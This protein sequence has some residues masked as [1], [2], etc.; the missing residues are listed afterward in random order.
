[1]HAFYVMHL[2]PVTVAFVKYIIVE[3]CQHMFSFSADFYSFFND[4]FFVTA[5]SVSYI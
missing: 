5:Y 4:I 3:K 2:L 1:V